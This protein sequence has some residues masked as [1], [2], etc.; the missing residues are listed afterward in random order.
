MHDEENPMKEIRIEK[1]TLNMGVGADPDELKKGT[2]IIE[3]VSGAKTIQTLAKVKQPT[4]N[5][6]PG[7]PIGIKTTLRKAS[8]IEFLKRAFQAKNNKIL[9]RNFDE[10]GNFAFGI[11]E[12]IDLPKTKY[13]PKLGV[14]GFDVIV[15]L[16]RKGYRIKKRKL[17]Q[18]K[19]GK[20]HKITKESAIDFVTKIFGV[21][22]E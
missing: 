12:Y 10:N 20:N 1:I 15:T 17:R 8:A 21:E 9:K 11:K 14:K 16:E 22:V 6:R 18:Q 19:L 13:D 4:W 5:I 7:V 3:K 2:E